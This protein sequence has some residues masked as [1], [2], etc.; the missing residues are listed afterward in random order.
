MFDAIKKDNARYAAFAASRMAASDKE[1]ADMARYNV[2]LY[3][4]A[5]DSSSATVRP[6]KQG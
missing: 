5:A 2:T 4:G 6:A 1:A 3:A